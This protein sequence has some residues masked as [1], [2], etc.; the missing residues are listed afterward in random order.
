MESA[1]SMARVNDALRNLF[2]CFYLDARAEGV[3]ILPVLRSGQVEIFSLATGDDQIT[4]PLREF[5]APPPEMV[6]AQEPWH[7]HDRF[8]HSPRSRPAPTSSAAPRP[9]APLFQR[10]VSDMA[11]DRR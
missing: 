1:D 7:L 11:R 10:A 3:V 8:P 2:E 4:P 6:N 9:V 5:R